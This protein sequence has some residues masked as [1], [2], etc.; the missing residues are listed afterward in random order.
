VDYLKEDIMY[1]DH[2][3]HYYPRYYPRYYPHYVYHPYYYPD[4]YAGIYQD[5]YN[6]G[7]MED[8]YQYANINQMRA[9]GTK[10]RA[11]KR[12]NKRK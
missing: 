6:S 10:I 1:Y 11:S 7:Y 5:I 3:Y 12:S 9:P 8:V 4:Y 2:Y